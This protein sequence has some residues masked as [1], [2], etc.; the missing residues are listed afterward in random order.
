MKN[1]S[2]FFA[3]FSLFALLVMAA[4]TFVNNDFGQL[5]SGCICLT[6]L[7]L[8]FASDVLEKNLKK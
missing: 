4:A 7:T 8:A 5:L 1:Y 2:T 3:F 6:S